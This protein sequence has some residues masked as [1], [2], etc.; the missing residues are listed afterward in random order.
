[1]NIEVYKCERNHEPCIFDIDGI[2]DLNTGFSSKKLQKVNLI[3][4][5]KSC[6]VM[7][8]FEILC[9]EIDEY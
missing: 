8:A 9:G 4:V 6:V 3:F 7:L 2:S 5:K 1:M